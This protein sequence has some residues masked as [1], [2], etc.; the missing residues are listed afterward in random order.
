MWRVENQ[1]K[2]LFL[3]LRFWVFITGNNS[4]LILSCATFSFLFIH[5]N[6]F[7]T[8]ILFI[9]LEKS[10][11]NSVETYQFLLELCAAENLRRSS[12]H[13]CPHTRI[14]T[15]FFQE[16]WIWDICP[17]RKATEQRNSRIRS[18]ESFLSVTMCALYKH[19]PH[20]LSQLSLFPIFQVGALPHTREH[21]F[22]GRYTA[23]EATQR[24]E[25]Q[26][27]KQQYS[28]HAE[29]VGAVTQESEASRRNG[30]RLIL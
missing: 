6:I 15:Q 8:K 25:R 30:Q 22:L 18:R 27:V 12:Y 20:K 13:L 29:P 14:F 16:K 9:Q 24:W 17:L 26:A 3:S 5:S 21:R 7:Y 19:F 28:Q 10:M 4:L 11:L 23:P 1:R 2:F